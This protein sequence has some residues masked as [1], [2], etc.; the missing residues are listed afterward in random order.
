VVHDDVQK[1]HR[2]HRQAAAGGGQV[3][4]PHSSA[5]RMVSERRRG[6]FMGAVERV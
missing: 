6:L 5:A 2:A 4:Q 3:E 1:Q